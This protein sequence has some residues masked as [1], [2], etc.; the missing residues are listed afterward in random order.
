LRALAFD[1]R[2]RQHHR[3]CKEIVVR[4]SIAQN[5]VVGKKVSRMSSSRSKKKA[6]EISVSLSSQASNG[7]THDSTAKTK[8]T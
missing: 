4:E 3:T 7:S 5:E 6:S 8:I 1:H 2:Q